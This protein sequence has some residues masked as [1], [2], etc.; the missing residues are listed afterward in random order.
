MPPEFLRTLF[1][2]GVNHCGGGEGPHSDPFD[3][4]HKMVEWLESGVAPT[5]VLA[6]HRTGAVVDRPSRPRDNAQSIWF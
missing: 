5:S 4:L 2:P 6:S 1:A 3:L